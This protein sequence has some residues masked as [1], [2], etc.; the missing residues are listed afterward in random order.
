MAAKKV[1]EAV[2]L[3]EKAYSLLRRSDIRNIRISSG[4]LKESIRHAKVASS[5]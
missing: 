2:V 5:I 3:M 1:T 4:F